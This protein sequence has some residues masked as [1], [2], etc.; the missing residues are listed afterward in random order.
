LQIS[1][2]LF[3]FRW[4]HLALRCLILKPQPADVFFLLLG[5]LLVE[6]G[7]RGAYQLVSAER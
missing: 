3:F 6:R 2:D 7:K 4:M 1:L 5:A